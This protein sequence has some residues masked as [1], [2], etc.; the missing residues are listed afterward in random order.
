MKNVFPPY[1]ALLLVAA[2]VAGAAAQSGRKVVR[3]TQ[4]VPPVQAPVFTPAEAEAET[5]RKSVAR[6]E[7]L[8]LP[9]SLRERS[10]KSLDNDR[11]RLSDFSGKVVVVNLW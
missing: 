5:I 4:P 3:A 9:N 6:P 10:L 7:L 11:F 2:F 8:R 1:L